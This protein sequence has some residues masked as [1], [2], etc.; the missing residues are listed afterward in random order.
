MTDETKR[1][2]RYSYAQKL[3]NNETRKEYYRKKLRAENEDK[4]RNSENKHENNEKQS[5]AH[6]RE[7]SYKIEAERQKQAAE[8]KKSYEKKV[9]KNNLAEYAARTSYL[10]GCVNRQSD[11]ESDTS[12]N[13][14][15]TGGEIVRSAVKSATD[16]T[17]S[18][19]KNRVYSSKI[20]ER[21]GN[22][23][24]ENRK[25]AQKKFNKKKLYRKKIRKSK[26]SELVKKIKKTVGEG[27]KK[28]LEG[29]MALTRSHP[30]AAVVILLIIVLL[31]ILIAVYSSG[32][33][34]FLGGTGLT[35]GTSFTADDEDILAVEEDYTAL[36]DELR[37]KIS[38]IESDNPDYD[39]YNYYLDDI[40]H[41]PYE[42][43]ALLTV[44]YEDYTRDEVQEKLQEIFDLQYEY[45]TETEVETHTND[46]GETE[47]YKILNVYLTNN[48]IS[49]IISEMG[50]TDDQIERYNILVLTHGNKEY[51][52]DDETT[53]TT[54]SGESDEYSVPAEYLTNQQFS[55]MMTEAEKY[56]GM[57]YVWGGSSPETGF[58]CSGY[59]SWVIN[60][61][62]NGWNL[63]RQ[64]AEGLKNS[65]DRVS[66]KEVR[67]GDLIFFK[68][69]YGTNGASH[70]GIVVDPVKKI[71]LH[72]G[73]PIQYASYD[74]NYWR[75]HE[76]CY[77]R[78]RQGG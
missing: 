5:I 76:Y 20:H 53:L 24:P 78:I 34:M 22:L 9:Y 42:L 21:H 10:I 30:V 47:E 23:R 57:E 51:L 36:E 74:T 33:M 52:F 40:E 14:C 67:S 17:S 43:A 63:G 13:V 41:D 37:D 2:I 60:N 16:K 68:G 7:K 61:C 62:G 18:K 4:D 35:I 25:N 31:V 46:D 12:E 39:E 38:N 64:S 11:E 28:I 26:K 54:L 45:W 75:Q 69:T 29:I 58:D 15:E 32:G 66:E 71:M 50:L 73:S 59:V 44:I 55:K 1:W 70:V 56:L 6:G 48:T 65:T 8:I 49:G 19:M 72:C 27:L 77:G 3:R